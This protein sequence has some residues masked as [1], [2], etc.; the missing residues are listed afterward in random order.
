ML[1]VSDATLRLY[2]AVSK[3]T[4]EEMACGIVESFYCDCGIGITGIA[5]PDGGSVERPVGLV[6]ICVK[7]K[8]EIAIKENIFR[9]S[10]EMIQK[11][12]ALCA[13]QMF[14]RISG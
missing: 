6:Y 10:R 14:K 9:G 3:Q 4:A 11:R 5:G 1:R 12:S 8:G 13:F 2:G 7:F